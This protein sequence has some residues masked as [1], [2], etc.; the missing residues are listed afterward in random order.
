MK[1]G[2]LVLCL[3]ICNG[4]FIGNL[5]FDAFGEELVVYYRVPQSSQ[6][7]RLDFINETIPELLD[8]TVDTDGPYRLEPLPKMVFQ[9]VAAPGVQKMYPNIIIR[10]TGDKSTQEKFEV[11]PIPINRGIVGYRLFLIHEDMQQKFD[12][13][14][15]LTD[16]IASGLTAGQGRWTDVDILEENNLQ[17]V[18][19]N[20]YEGLFKMLLAG[21]FNYFPRGV[22]EI[23]KEMAERKVKLPKMKIEKKL[24]IYYPLPRVFVTNKGNTVFAK[25]IERGLKAIIA[26]GTHEKIWWKFNRENVINAQLDKRKI[27]I[28]KNPYALPNLPYDDPKYWYQVG[29]I[30]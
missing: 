12:K 9:R 5:S 6:D 21:R 13:I 28:L 14:A 19:G 16:L 3:L 11:V 29:E 1:V 10:L 25:R 2:I 26:D 20:N 30:K 15:S 24:A 17:V 18:V 27:F 8:R 22:N 4:F 7:H 23:F